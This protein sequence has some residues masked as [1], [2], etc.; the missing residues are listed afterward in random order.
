MIIGI[1]TAVTQACKCL[2]SCVKEFEKKQMFVCNAQKNVVA[3]SQLHLK[4]LHCVVLCGQCSSIYMK[5]FE[6]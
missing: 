1:L 6:R 4:I 5:G 2:T 3:L